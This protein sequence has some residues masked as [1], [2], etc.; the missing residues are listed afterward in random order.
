MDLLQEVSGGENVMSI[1]FADD[2][3]IKASGT[4][5]DECLI[6]V[7]FIL[8]ALNKWAYK[9]RMIINCDPNKTEL[10]CFNTAEGE[11]NLVPK[12]FRLG[13]KVVRRV[14]QTKVLGLII[15]EKL[16]FQQHSD[17]VYQK[18]ILKWVLICK[19]SNSNGAS[20]K[21]LWYN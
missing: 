10:I 20:I 7:Q 16:T 3:T 11:V 1:K 12:E 4:S 14:K 21:E 18:L 9:W 6:T 2:G 8:S 15:D 13:D 5:T 19:H 17:Y